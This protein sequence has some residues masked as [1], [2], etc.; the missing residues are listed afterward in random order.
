MPESSYLRYLPPVLW[1]GAPEDPDFSL[2]GALRVFEKILTGIAD[3]VPIPHGGHAHPPIGELIARLDR[4]FDPWTT[5]PEFLPWLASWVSL[6]FP[7]I[8]GQQLWDEYQRRKATAEI[9]RIH[10]RRGLRSGLNT[11]LDL[12]SVG[13]VRPRVALDDGSCLYTA[14]LEAGLPAPVSALP[15]FRPLIEGTS[16]VVREGLMR[17]WCVTRAPDGSLFVG[18]RG[19]PEDVAIAPRRRVWRLNPAGQPDLV[20]SPPLPRPLVPAQALGQIIAVTVRPARAGQPETLFILDHTGRIFSVPAPYTAESATELTRISPAGTSVFPLAMAVDGQGD[21]LVLDRKLVPGEVATPRVFVIRPSPLAVTVKDLDQNLIKE[22]LSLFVDR[23]GAL[24]IG[25][26]G[27]QQ[28]PPP[29]GSGGGNLVRVVRG[30]T[31]WTHTRLLPPDNAL[32]APT[33]VARTAANRLYALDA[34]LKPFW[35]FPSVTTDAF[36]LLKALP[37]CV[38]LVETPPGGTAATTLRVTEPGHFVNPTGMTAVGEH[39]IICDP[40]QTEFAGAGL[41]TYQSRI[42]PFEINVVIHFSATELSADPVKQRRELNQAVGTIK[43][44]VEQHKP[45]HCRFIEVTTI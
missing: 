5:P 26:G 2:A 15:T 29:P 22:P 6:G 36:I 39:L 7:E 27:D 3:E 4:L 25:D 20:G 13:K 31:A 30:S 17:P 19:L 40:G 34:G 32:V 28:T 35:P 12:Y 41:P 44:I 14:R 18:D 21:L 9:T 10:R 11:F 38:H 1:E 43:A 16:E 42:Q 37:A 24:V 45:A 33:A 8:Q 23:D